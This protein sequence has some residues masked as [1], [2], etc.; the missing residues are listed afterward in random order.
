M[1][2][3]DSRP[4]AGESLKL[5]AEDG[6]VIMSVS[7]PGDVAGS[8]ANGFLGFVLEPGDKLISEINVWEGGSLNDD[9]GFNF[10]SFASVP[11]PGAVWLLGSGLIGLVGL[12]N[13]FKK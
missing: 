6:S 5:F 10:V 4:E 11:I 12:R 3:V 8:G 1:L 13:K 2:I 9:I 7:L